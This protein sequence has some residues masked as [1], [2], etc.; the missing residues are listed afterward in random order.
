MMEAADEELPAE[1]LQ[2]DQG[3]LEGLDQAAKRG[4]LS[5][6][7][8]TVMRSYRTL[9]AQVTPSNQVGPKT[10]TGREEASSE[11]EGK[12]VELGCP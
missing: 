4:I 11:V 2:H 3:W 9:Q 6:D 10:Y 12:Q 7:E 8:Q 1:P 5:D